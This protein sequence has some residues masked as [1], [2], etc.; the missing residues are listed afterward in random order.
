MFNSFLKSVFIHIVFALLLIFAYLSPPTI[1]KPTKKPVVLSFSV[2]NVTKEETT[3][4]KETTEKNI[5]KNLPLTA[6]PTPAEKKPQ[7]VKAT[8]IAPEKSIQPQ[9]KPQTT[10]SEVIKQATPIASVPNTLPLYAQ[11]PVQPSNPVLPMQKAL[12][13]QPETAP[14]PKEQIQVP[15]HTP[16]QAITSLVAVSSSHKQPLHAVAPVRPSMVSLP[17]QKPNQPQAEAAPSMVAPTTP[18]AIVA[19]SSVPQAMAHSMTPP[20]AAPSP[21]ALTQSTPNAPSAQ[22]TSADE[23]N[24]AKQEYLR[25]VAAQIKKYKTYPKE[26]KKNNNIMGN[27]KVI[28]RIA[29]DGKI[30]KIGIV[31]SSGSEI[32]DKAA[33][34]LILG[35][36]KFQA[37]PTILGK[38]YMDITLNIDYTLK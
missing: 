9:A 8:P 4:K 33:V 24:S 6:K 1:K 2:P 34:D 11:A 15:L 17:M 32:L 12:L 26:A 31:S 23:A 20:P 28:F 27:V 29:A 36:T 3:V 16:V 38:E 21:S 13:P 25:S 35:I 14:S 22:V 18:M 30:L 37:L 19:P 10:P 5:P 7:E